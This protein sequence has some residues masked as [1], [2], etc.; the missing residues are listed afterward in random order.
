MW[1]EVTIEQSQNHA[2]VIL[3]KVL[4]LTVK[5][6]CSQSW[7]KLKILFAD[8]TIKALFQKDDSRTRCVRETSSV[9]GKR[10][11]GNVLSGNRPVRETS[12]P[13]NVRKP[14]LSSYCFVWTCHYLITHI[15]EEPPAVCW[16]TVPVHW[17]LSPLKFVHYRPRRRGRRRYTV[18]HIC[19]WPC[20]PQHT[21]IVHMVPCKLRAIQGLRA[22][23]LQ[24]KH[25]IVNNNFGAQ[26]FR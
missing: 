24:N 5:T 20:K 11:A 17:S 13:G 6:E 12:C 10:L 21:H 2:A 7:I 23:A 3:D 14:V 9:S 22:V 15:L 8:V 4:K 19:N 16:R 25:L 18:V 1:T 26:F